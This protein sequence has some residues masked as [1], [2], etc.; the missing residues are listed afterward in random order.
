MHPAIKR[1]LSH[2]SVTA[3]PSLPFL[4]ASGRV[5]DSLELEDT[6]AA[7]DTERPSKGASSRELPASVI[8]DQRK[9][10]YER[11][12][13]RDDARVYENDAH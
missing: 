9:K 5:R 7:D 12:R 8:E 3:S 11:C 6:L 10:R 13:M 2:D 4:S 1:P